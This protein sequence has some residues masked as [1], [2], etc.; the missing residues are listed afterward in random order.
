MMKSNQGISWLLSTAMLTAVNGHAFAQSDR[1][2]AAAQERVLEVIVVTARGREENLQDTP[3]SVATISETTIQRA[4]V[5]RATDFLGLVP[6]VTI[7][8]AQDSG[9]VAINIRGVGQ[10]RNGET[11]VA[12]SVDGVLLSSPLQFSQEFFDIKQI[13]VLRGPQGA[14]YGRNAIAGAINITTKMPTDEFSGNFS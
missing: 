10:I 13:E 1:S 3:V 6:N 7:A 5:R 8:D 9:N 14:L 2:K 11:P 4:G 12:I